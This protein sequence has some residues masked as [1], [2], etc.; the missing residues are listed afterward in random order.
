MCYAFLDQA[1]IFELGSSI[2]SLSGVLQAID[3]GAF[4]RW[5]GGQC[6]DCRTAVGAGWG[7]SQSGLAPLGASN[8][9]RNQKAPTGVGATL[10]ARGVL[11]ACS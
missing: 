5:S 2:P 8:R 4:H 11:G 1:N 7:V 3:A 9:G 10:R 6:Q